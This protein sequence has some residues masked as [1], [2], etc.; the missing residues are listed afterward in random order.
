MKLK[1]EKS[2]VLHLGRS[3]SHTLGRTGGQDLGD[4]SGHQ[5]C[6]LSSL[7]TFKSHLDAVMDDGQLALGALI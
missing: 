7:D 6:G 2:R 1:K 5:G 3:N 4:P